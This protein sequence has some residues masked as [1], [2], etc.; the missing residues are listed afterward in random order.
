M[1]T[2]LVLISQR[3]KIKSAE[4]T[5]YYS[6]Y[7]LPLQE[8]CRNEDLKLLQKLSQIKCSS[9]YKALNRRNGPWLTSPT[10]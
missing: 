3:I 1:P 10:C 5:I 6:F 4:L 7:S 2:A 9:V 8:L